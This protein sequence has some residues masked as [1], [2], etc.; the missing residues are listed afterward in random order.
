MKGILEGTENVHF[1]I[2]G[3]K[4]CGKCFNQWRI[5]QEN[6]FDYKREKINCDDLEEQELIDLKIRQIPVVM[7]YDS[8]K[9]IKRYNEYVN[10][11]DITKF[12]YEYQK[13]K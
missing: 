2:Y 4:N 9:L 8:D 3:N 6:F 7:I 12:L 1:V 13:R 11:D 10:P 5:I